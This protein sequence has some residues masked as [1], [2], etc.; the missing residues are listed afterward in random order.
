MSDGTDLSALGS[1]CRA[2]ECVPWRRSSNPAGTQESHS[3]SWEPARGHL[4]LPLAAPCHTSAH[5]SGCGEGV[6]PVGPADGKEDERK[7]KQEKKNE[8]KGDDF[9]FNC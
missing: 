5:R 2:G 9:M 4:K 1:Q 3:P 6:G 7:K 8:A